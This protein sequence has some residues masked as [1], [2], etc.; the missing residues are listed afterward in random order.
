MYHHAVLITI[1]L[2]TLSKVVGHY[3]H[4]NHQFQ[5]LKLQ[6]LIFKKH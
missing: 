3:K 5:I 6:I 2:R 1:R 4:D